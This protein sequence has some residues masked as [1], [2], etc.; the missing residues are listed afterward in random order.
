MK[1]PYCSDPNTQVV[2]TRENEE[3]ELFEELTL[4]AA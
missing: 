4:N 1:C 2:D 3:G